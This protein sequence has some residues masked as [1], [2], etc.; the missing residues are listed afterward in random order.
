MISCFNCGEVGHISPNYPCKN[1]NKAV[2][3]AAQPLRTVPPTPTKTT[4]RVFQLTAEKAKEEE[5]VITGTI[6]VNSR[7]AKVLF[8]TGASLSF[9]AQHF[10]QYLDKPS[11][12]MH[13][14]IEVEIA[15]GSKN[16]LDQIF[17]GC[18]IELGN[19]KVPIDLV[20]IPLGEF[21]VVIGM[22]WLAKHEATLS[23]NSK[24]L[25]FTAP[26]GE[27][28]M[29]YGERVSAPSKFLNSI[30]AKR[31]LR[32]GCTAYLAHVIDKTKKGPVL[33]DLPI[34][35]EFSDVFPDELPGLPPHRQIEFAIDL[36]PSSAPISKAPYRLA[37]TEMKE[38]MKQLQELLDNGFIRPSVS[39]WGA[40]VLFVK[41]KDGSMRLCI[42]YR[43]LNKVT[44]K[45]KYPLPRIDDLFDQLQGASYF[46]KIDLRSG[47]HQLRIKET[48]ISKT[49]F[50]TR[51]GHFEFLVMPF[52]LT[53]APAVFMD[54]MNRVCKPFLD[55]FV[56]V[57]I[58]DIL[59][60]SKS[61]EEHEEHLRKVLELLRRE[62]LYAK[63]S[64]CE[65]WLRE[66]QFLGHVISQEG[67]KVDPAKIEAISNWEP[68]KTPT[69]V[70][71]FLGL[72]GYY[73][74]FIDDFSRIAIPLTSL[75]RKN[76]K[77]EWTESRK[78]AFET[79]KE[80]LI[81]APVLTLPDG[82]EDFV[83]YSDAS[84]RGLGCVLMQR[85]KVIA[86]ASR[87]LKEHEKR[88]PTHD[89]E[90]AA[91][92]FA[93][94]I[95][96]H[97]LFGEKCD[98]YTDHKSLKYIFTQKELNMRQ[99]RWLELL[100]D[101]NCRIL[102]HP[103]KANVVADALSR[104]EHTKST[105]L[106]A[107][108][109][110]VKTELIEKIKEVQRDFTDE[111]DRKKVRVKGYES[112]LVAN[113]DQILCYET[114]FWIPQKGGVRERILSEAHNSRY[115]IHPGSVKMYH[116]LKERYWWP[117]MKKDV[118][119][120]V[121]KC[122]T[123]QQVKAEHQK[124][125]GQLQP[126]EIPVWKWEHITMDFITKLPR[127]QKGNDTIWVIVDRLTKSAHFLPMKETMSMERLAQLYINEIVSRH[128]VP[129]SIVSYRDSRFT[130]NFWK[131]IQ[132]ELGTT[133]NMSTTYHPQTDGQS[134]RT[135]Q[136]LEDMLRSCVIDFKGNWDDHLPLV[137]F[138]YNNS[139]HTSIKAA[140]YEALYGRKCRTPVCWFDVG[141]KRELGPELIQQTSA[142]ID[143]IRERMKAAQDRQKSYADLKRRPMEFQVGDRV[144]LKVSPWK[145]IVRFQKRGKLSPRF[146]GP[147]KIIER[148]GNLAYRLELPSELQKLHNAFHVS[149]LR[150]CLSK[151]EKKI[152]YQ[153]V[154]VSEELSYIEEPECF[155]DRKVKVLRNKEIPIVKVQWRHH[156]GIEATWEP[157]EEMKRKYPRLFSSG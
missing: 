58:D 13:P 157:E 69:E 118:N 52:G 20:P 8:D 5:G 51:Y 140:P 28:I 86:Y 7:Y 117:G 76:V 74:R 4:G 101:Y 110:V 68:P 82:N 113:N 152:S 149:N 96:R 70:R 42:D 122:L 85:G 104:K 88:Y 26:D 22:D 134:E 24:M 72:A 124:P 146:I 141:E 91:V 106:K 45:N 148:V 49:A 130:S 142:K 21:D 125:Y 139:Y 111:A 81:N 36:V 6:L 79:L 65:F 109:I 90:L 78:K 144:L 115:S 34:V 10:S 75:T 33:G 153:D 126:L 14:K 40:P 83:V 156:D 9:V 135:I 67:I 50:R 108:P 136:T 31:C 1:Q 29:F 16:V 66:V 27:K 59:V 60:Y 120:W 73:R 107:N 114:R 32:K 89:L 25:T 121:Q 123:C 12:V 102:Y 47:Y 39:P 155:L 53:N 61:K 150:K 95:W 151:E 55:K 63:L 145:G 64:K 3:T 112:M 131:S 128:G 127:T 38:L 143:T 137:E 105:M 133:L 54:L 84:N 119:E 92:V 30:Q 93:L 46:S 98:I 154:E 147:F 44:I 99:R 35:H 19:K 56:I 100:K 129:V 41:K 48:D 23:C 132:R 116:D 62:K 11:I 71:S 138:A 18:T 87:Q 94:K 37:P 17:L 15:N 43:E 103:G 2:T 77:F 97:Y 57:F 80:K